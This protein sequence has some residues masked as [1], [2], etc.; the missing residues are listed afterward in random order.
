M[1][2]IYQTEEVKILWN[3]EKCIH[4]AE[5]IKGAP[6]VFNPKQR[7]WVQLE[8]DTAENIRSTVANCPSGALTVV[9]ELDQVRIDAP[10]TEIT[11][12][13][14][15]PAIVSG[16]IGINTGSGDELKSGKIALCRCSHTGNRPFCDGTHAKYKFE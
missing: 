6:R 9:E 3:S 14:N 16:T 4:A 5:C 12:V 15:G 8:N 2:K 11:I 13:Q 7:P 1:E 10:E